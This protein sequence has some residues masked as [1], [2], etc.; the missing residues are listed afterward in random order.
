[1]PASVCPGGQGSVMPALPLVPGPL[2]AEGGCAAHPISSVL[3]AHHQAVQ[4]RRQ[5][6]EL[7][8][9]CSLV[10]AD[11]THQHEDRGE[12]ALLQGVVLSGD[13]A[14]K[15]AKVRGVSS[16]WGSSGGPW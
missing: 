15:R 12:E 2:H 9:L 8:A 10:T 16:G 6:L 11:G 1:M 13:P 5:L 3:G 4:Q 14:G 7:I